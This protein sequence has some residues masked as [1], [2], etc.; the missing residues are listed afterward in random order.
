MAERAG[1]FFNRPIVHLRDDTPG[2][3]I[4]RLSRLIASPKPCAGQSLARRVRAVSRQPQSGRL[5][6]WKSDSHLSSKVQAKLGA[7]RSW[8]A[9]QIDI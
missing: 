3:W 2:L 1:D 6:G 9:S 7:T 4:R 8:S 5:I